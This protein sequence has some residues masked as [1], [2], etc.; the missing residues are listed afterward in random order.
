MRYRETGG[1]GRSCSF[2]LPV[3]I[4]SIVISVHEI[5]V[6]S[7]KAELQLACSALVLG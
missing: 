1:K 7:L 5:T 3:M 6:V 2:T 4:K